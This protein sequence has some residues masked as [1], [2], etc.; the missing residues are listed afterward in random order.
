MAYALLFL[1]WARTVRVTIPE[2]T[3]AA[4]QSGDQG[5]KDG[6]AGLGDDQGTRVGRP[7]PSPAASSEGDRSKSGASPTGM[8]SEATEGLHGADERQEGD[9]SSVASDRAQG[10]KE[11]KGSEPLDK[12]RSNEHRSGYGGSGGAPVTSSDQREPNSPKR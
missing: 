4:G 6:R 9:K 10:K 1:D 2:G 5:A 3:M 7:D 11:R 12:E 8:G